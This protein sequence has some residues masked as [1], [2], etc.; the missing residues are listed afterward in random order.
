MSEKHVDY[1]GLAHFKEKCDELY[2]NPKDLSEFETECYNTYLRGALTTKLGGSAYVPR[3]NFTTS[4]YN[5]YYEIDGNISLLYEN[6]SPADMANI[7][8]SENGNYII[9]CVVPLKV[10]GTIAI[11]NGFVCSVTIKRSGTEGDA[12]YIKPCSLFSS[13]SSIP[14]LSRLNQLVQS[15]YSEVYERTHGGIYDYAKSCVSYPSKGY[16]WIGAICTKTDLCSYFKIDRTNIF[17]TDLKVYNR[18]INLSYQGKRYYYNISTKDYHTSNYRKDSISSSISY[19]SINGSVITL[20]GGYEGVGA[21]GNDPLSAS[22]ISGTD[23]SF[24][25]IMPDCSIDV[26][27][28]P[29]GIYYLVYNNSKTTVG[30]KG[31]NLEIPKGLINFQN[32]YFADKYS[33][34]ITPDEDDYKYLYWL[35]DTHTWVFSIGVGEKKAAVQ[36]TDSILLAKYYWNAETSTITDVELM[37]TTLHLATDKFVKLYVENQMQYFNEK[38]SNLTDEL[39]LLKEKIKE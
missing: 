29:S 7:N 22:T 24:I 36:R 12:L 33:D 19:I 6:I 26:A 2:L 9:L 3:P 31:G 14:K 37:A 4:D 27:G 38:I 5:V 18:R 8:F 17:T 34:I 28:Y 39:N 35:I 21:L 30:T 13:K 23:D 15:K 32:L 25:S 20:P 1:E 16:I 10:D 11:A